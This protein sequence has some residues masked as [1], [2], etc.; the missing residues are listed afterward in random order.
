MALVVVLLVTIATSMCMLVMTR[1]LT[2]SLV[3]TVEVRRC[4]VVLPVKFL[5]AKMVLLA[6]TSTRVP[7]LDVA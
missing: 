7:T 6:N 1:R 3:T 5:S 2:L 4:M